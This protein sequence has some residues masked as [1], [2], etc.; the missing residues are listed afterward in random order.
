MANFI[1]LYTPDDYLDFIGQKRTGRDVAVVRFENLQPKSFP[2][3][4]QI[5]YYAVF[6]HPDEHIDLVY[7]TE[8]IKF[9]NGSL[10][11]M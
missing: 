8:P 3:V 11:F 4:I 2:E 5:G 9:G 7:G 10:L 6:Y 1:K